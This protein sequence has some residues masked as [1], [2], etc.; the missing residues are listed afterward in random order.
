MSESTTA[1]DFLDAIV[2]M[3]SELGISRKVRLVT[4]GSLDANNPGAGRTQTP[5]DY[6]VPAILY[7]YADYQIDGTTIQDGD[8]LAIVDIGSLSA[9]V[10][11]EILPNTKLVDGTTIYTIVRV[12]SAEVVGKKIVVILQIRS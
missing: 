7:D 3:L 11:D 10:I 9:S 2:D 5:T 4:Y 8:R 12:T 6:T 1:Q